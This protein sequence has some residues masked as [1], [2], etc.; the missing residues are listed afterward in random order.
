MDEILLKY[1]T[2]LKTVKNKLNNGISDAT[3]KIV[4][5]LLE[6]VVKD[7]EKEKVRQE[8]NSKAVKNIRNELTPLGL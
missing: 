1:Q 7:L 5:D 8:T 4:H 3:L 6:E 2:K